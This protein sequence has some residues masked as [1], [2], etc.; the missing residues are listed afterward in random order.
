MSYY[1]KEVVAYRFS[2]SNPTYR[3]KITYPKDI[4]HS[5]EKSTPFL[6]S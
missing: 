1:I 4:S 6:L 2:Q 3:W 5:K